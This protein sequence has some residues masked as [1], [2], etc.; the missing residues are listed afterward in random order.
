MNIKLKNA[1]KYTIKLI[2][3][4]FLA[5]FFFISCN[6]DDNVSE[7]TSTDNNPLDLQKGIEENGSW[8]QHIYEENVIVFNQDLNDLLQEVTL[9]SITMT[10]NPSLE[11]IAEGDVLFSDFTDEN[12]NGFSRVVIG[13]NRLQNSTTFITRQ[14]S[15]IETFLSMN[16]TIVF[17]DIDLNDALVS[18]IN[19]QLEGLVEGT[20]IEIQASD[21]DLGI[22]L[23]L[24][25]D[26]DS[27]T[28]FDNKDA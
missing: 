8:G 19:L 10:N 9:N 18:D 13:I 12:S 22:Q 20:N 1:R 24:D 14:A 27:N 28:E 5:A 25:S 26:G 6:D 21:N 3:S 15:F 11:L 23:T 7:E 4:L 2:L 17:H 16:E